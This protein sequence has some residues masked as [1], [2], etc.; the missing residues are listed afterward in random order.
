M[1]SLHAHFSTNAQSAK[2]VVLLATLKL[3]S[4]S[5]SKSVGHFLNI[6]PPV[7]PSC[8]CRQNRKRGSMRSWGTFEVR[9]ERASCVCQQMQS[10]DAYA[11]Q[12]RD[13]FWQKIIRLHSEGTLSCI[14]CI[15]CFYT[16]FFGMGGVTASR[17]R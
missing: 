8:L 5:A 17:A 1:S 13:S 9:I 14:L 2:A 6:P 10:A 15:S 3:K 11:A 4:R 7:S 12:F 16:A